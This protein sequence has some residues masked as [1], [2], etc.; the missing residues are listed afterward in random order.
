MKREREF[1]D[2]MWQKVSTLE[3]ESFENARVKAL[4]RRLVIKDLGML[5]AMALTL[6]TL[7]FFSRFVGENIFPLT[8]TMLTIG[9]ALEYLEIKAPEGKKNG[10]NHLRPY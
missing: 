9:F 1:L 2:G 7:T 3:R 8:I 10:N 6:L 5:F 4:H